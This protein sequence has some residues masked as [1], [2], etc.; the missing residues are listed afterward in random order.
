L[1]RLTIVACASLVASAAASQPVV[2]ST[3]SVG[4]VGCSAKLTRVSVLVPGDKP[5]QGLP[6]H[7]VAMVRDSRGRIFTSFGFGGTNVLPRVFAPDGKLIKI[8]GRFGT[9]PRELEYVMGLVA[10]DADSMLLLDSRH[11]YIIGPNL[12][13]V[14][15]FPPAMMTMSSEA[16]LPGSRRI[17]WA[18][19]DV[20]K[21]T[22]TVAVVDVRG[23]TLTSVTVPYT[24][25]AVSTSPIARF[26]AAGT[27]GFWWTPSNE[28]RLEWWGLDGKPRVLIQRA[29]PWWLKDTG[30]PLN[31]SKGYGIAPGG[32]PTRPHSSINDIRA[33]GTKRVWT[34]GRVLRKGVSARDSM[35]REDPARHPYDR[36]DTVLEIFDAKTGKLLVSQRLDGY[37]SHLLGDGYIAKLTDDVDGQPIVE[38]WKA[39]LTGV[40]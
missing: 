5:D 35:F 3:E 14:A 7:P 9:G 21:Q 15:S 26:S 38:I 30:T 32:N 6:A 39:T 23:K 37:F 2:R 25:P 11:R 40:R 33:E 1:S 31:P 36:Y 19:W 13:F 8:L 18:G 28:Y 34:L 12:D 24:L 17:T 27:D 10:L 20:A 4:C 22:A 16:S 29:A